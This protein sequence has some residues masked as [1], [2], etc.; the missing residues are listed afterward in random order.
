M[1]KNNEGSILIETAI[2]MQLSILFILILIG[3][4]VKYHYTITQDLYNDINGYYNSSDLSAEDEVNNFY[5]IK[6]NKEKTNDNRLKRIQQLKFIDDIMDQVTITSSL[7]QEYKK[8]I[9]EVEQI[10]SQ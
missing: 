6:I 7:K 1:I 5:S 10:L 8:K 2:I 4:T 9:E 3:M